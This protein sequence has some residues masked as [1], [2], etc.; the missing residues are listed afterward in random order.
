MLLASLVAMTLSAALSQ[1]ALDSWGWRIE[2]ALGAVT[3]IVGFAVRRTMPESRE[4]S[5]L[6]AT[7]VTS[8][9]PLRDALR[10]ARK[11]II[12]VGLLTGYL[13]IAY[14]IVAT[15]LVGYLVSVVGITQTQSLVISTVVG[16][17]YAVTALSWGRLSDRVGRRRPMLWS[18]VALAVLAYPAFRLLSSDN[19]PL[20]YLGE[21]ILLLPV[22][23]FT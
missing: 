17:I 22:M 1:A 23:M 12:I 18:A 13:G 2:Y 14:Y 6:K 15:F 20:I 11:P 3:A 10:T 5:R 19:L 8:R 4:F 21:L 7:G 9:T 16:A